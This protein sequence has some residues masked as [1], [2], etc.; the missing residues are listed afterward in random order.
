MLLLPS[1][2]GVVDAGEQQ[3]DREL[4]ERTTGEKGGGRR[5]RRR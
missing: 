4:D 3:K 2:A 5:R 1:L